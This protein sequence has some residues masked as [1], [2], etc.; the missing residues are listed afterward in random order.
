MGLGSVPEAVC[1]KDTVPEDM[2]WKLRVAAAVTTQLRLS[3]SMALMVAEFGGLG[4]V[5]MLGGG[6][7]SCVSRLGSEEP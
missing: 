6:G 7:W 2:C 4:E 3:S 1:W 5:V